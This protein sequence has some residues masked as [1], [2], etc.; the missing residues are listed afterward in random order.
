MSTT[1]GGCDIDT[2]SAIDAAPGTYVLLFACRAPACCAVG[3]L[4]RVTL[5]PGYYLYVGSAF[6]PGGVRARVARHVRR[7]KSRHWHLDYLCEV[8]DPLEVWYTLDAA[9]REHAL[10]AALGA[11]PGLSGVR[12]FG[13]SDCAC[14]SHLFAT[15][16]PPSAGRLARSTGVALTVWR[17]VSECRVEPGKV[18]RT[19]GG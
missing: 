12:R 14:G 11:W 5:E 18:R 4:G 10:A 1:R 3:R 9:R 19:R 6:G 17:M 13:S 16:R 15:R 7:D 8:L 2:R